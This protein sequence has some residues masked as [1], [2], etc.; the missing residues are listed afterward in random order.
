MLLIYFRAPDIADSDQNTHFMSLN[1]QSLDPEEGIQWHF[2]LSHR[3]QE[4]SLTE[5]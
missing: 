5:E 4:T 1:T 2:H 3:S